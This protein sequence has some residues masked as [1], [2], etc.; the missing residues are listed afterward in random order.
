MQRLHAAHE[1]RLQEARQER[2]AARHGYTAASNRG[3][4]AYPQNNSS[5]AYSAMPGKLM[6]DG[7]AAYESVSV[8]GSGVPSPQQSPR[9]QL[10]A[11]HHGG[12]PEKKTQ[13]DQNKS[14]ASQ[15]SSTTAR[16]TEATRASANSDTRA[17]MNWVS[18]C[19]RNPSL[20][21]MAMS[22]S[23]TGSHSGSHHRR[24]ASSKP[25]AHEKPFRCGSPNAKDTQR[26]NL[27]QPSRT[28]QRHP[29]NAASATSLLPN[30]QPTRQPLLAKPK[31]PSPTKML[32]DN[33]SNVLVKEY[34]EQRGIQDR[35]TI[36]MQ[37]DELGNGRRATSPV[38]NGTGNRF[39]VTHG[40][41]AS[42]AAMYRPDEAS[43]DLGRPPTSPIRPQPYSHSPQP[44]SHPSYRDPF[45]SANVRFPGDHNRRGDEPK[46]IDDRKY[47]SPPQRGA[48][49]DDDQAPPTRR[50]PTTVPLDPNLFQYLNS[51]DLNSEAIR[52][53]SAAEAVANRPPQIDKS[54]LV[55]LVSPNHGRST[56]LNTTSNPNLSASGPL[57]FASSVVAAVPSYQQPTSSFLEHSSLKYQVEYLAL[58]KIAEL[59]QRQE[60]A[61]AD[62]AKLE[63]EERAR[64]Q[65][66]SSVISPPRPDRAEA[67]KPASPMSRTRS[68]RKSP[69]QFRQ[70]EDPAC[71]ELGLR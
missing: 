40:R 17:A 57:S 30:H 13:A 8:P 52:S 70:C 23:T 41:D 45:A 68:I 46:G 18:Q 38:R 50:P 42:A 4:D 69:T 66:S 53:F 37:K 36:K 15:S 44:I 51:T 9:P 54:P 48:T 59:E 5:S 11:Q 21:R 14:K 60:K 31:A 64:A 12:H 47:V 1:E 20:A 32:A 55:S 29:A 58:N 35:S 3:A 22:S 25:V 43:H 39:D 6:I 49:R 65:R 24:S 62:R 33:I 61:G 16:G 71:T 34:V 7:I 10:G 67:A 28:H 27:P 26:G 2:R 56:A 63:A 19:S